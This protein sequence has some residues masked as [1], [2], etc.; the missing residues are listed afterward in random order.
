M[1][2]PVWNCAESPVDLHSGMEKQM[3]KWP[4]SHPSQ[5]RHFAVNISL[6]AFSMTHIFASSPP[7]PPPPSDG[8]SA[9]LG[10]GSLVLPSGQRP[11]LTN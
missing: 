11:A 1:A 9:A 5:L 8:P 6:L 3:L 2:G 10:L 7:H 4:Y